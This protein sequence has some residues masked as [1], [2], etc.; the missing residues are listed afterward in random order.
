MS[1][2]KV[3]RAFQRVLAQINKKDAQLRAEVNLIKRQIELHRGYL[4]AC[5]EQLL[6]KHEASPVE[7]EQWVSEAQAHR[8]KTEDLFTRL[9]AANK[10]VQAFKDEVEERGIEAIP[11]SNNQK[12]LYGYAGTVH[13][14]EIGSKVMTEFG[15][16]EIVYYAAIR[17]QLASL[18]RQVRAT[19]AMLYKKPGAK[20]E[21]RSN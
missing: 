10:V 1:K 13:I 8:K 15:N 21:T 16:Q 12:I 2:I 3:L 20:H 6:V 19:Q 18:K 11:A 14:K 17:K 4:G 9:Q 5:M 7:L